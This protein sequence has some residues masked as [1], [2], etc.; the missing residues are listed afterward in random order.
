MGKL[1]TKGSELFLG[2]AA[3]SPDVLAFGCITAIS[4]LGGP[5]GQIDVSCWRSD[6]AEY[7]QGRAQP[8]A[9]TINGIYED[10][11]TSFVR[12]K[13]LM[14]DGSDGTDAPTLDSAGSFAGSP[15]TRTFVHWM[16]YVADVTWDLQDNNVWRWQ[17]QVQRS[18][19]WTLARKVVV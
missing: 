3:G 16:G 6:E 5:A 4:G 8:G 18:G 19:R 7:E 1:K 12:A 10:D 11:D 2:D 17:V 14:D 15:T 13:E 9:I